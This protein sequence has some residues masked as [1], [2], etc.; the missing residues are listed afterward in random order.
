VVESSLQFQSIAIRVLKLTEQTDGTPCDLAQQHA[1]YPLHNGDGA[2][3][4]TNNIGSEAD[5]AEASDCDA[6]LDSNANL[7]LIV[8]A[9]EHPEA[10]IK[11]IAE[12]ASQPNSPPSALRR[13]GNHHD[14]NSTVSHSAD[15]HAESA[16]PKARR[17]PMFA[18]DNTDAHRKVDA[19]GAHQQGDLMKRANRESKQVA[20]AAPSQIGSNHSSIAGYNS[21]LESVRKLALSEEA[22]MEPS[23]RCL[24]R[25]IRLTFIVVLVMAVVGFAVVQSSG[26]ALKRSVTNIYNAGV[27]RSHIVNIRTTLDTF[28]LVN[29][30]LQ[31]PLSPSGE[32]SE[33]N[34]IRR[35]VQMGFELHKKL[36]LETSGVGD[37]L[38]RLYS[39]NELPFEVLTAGQVSGSQVN[40]WDGINRVLA[41]ASRVAATPLAE[42]NNTHPDAFL[43]QENTAYDDPVFQGVMKVI[44][45]YQQQAEHNTQLVIQTQAILMAA[46]IG[47]LVIIVLLVFPPVVR[48]VNRTAHRI[49]ELFLDISQVQ[50]IEIAKSRDEV[51]VTLGAGSET[52]GKMAKALYAVVINTTLTHV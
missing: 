12:T 24:Q 28:V 52:G 20:E 40:L 23:I 34:N 25:F 43:I 47:V 14:G 29:E 18:D 16:V 48:H 42:I 37:A 38:E 45:L 44:E 26:G 3:D 15:A 7:H 6:K 11:A 49:F 50:I 33:R 31:S 36:Y 8:E 39:Q 5:G 22:P 46:A 21:A 35:S 10:D 19:S 27:L 32:A 1:G 2:G 13:R 41:A 51:L 30:R 17:R 4:S 9:P